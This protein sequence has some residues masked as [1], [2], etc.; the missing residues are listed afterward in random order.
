MS[1]GASRRRC[2]AW[3]H[4]QGFHGLSF[5]HNISFSA[6]SAADIVLFAADI[7]TQVGTNPQILP[8][9]GS[10]GSLKA[11]TSPIRAM[12]A[13]ADARISKAEKFESHLATCAY[14][15][16]CSC[17]TKGYITPYTCSKV[18]IRVDAGRWRAKNG[19]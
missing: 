14:Q 12:I 1:P 16:T 8:F 4:G 18:E 15:H 11:H 13:I 10:S 19:F 3:R 2:G 7:R 5:G 9:L 6:D 17:V